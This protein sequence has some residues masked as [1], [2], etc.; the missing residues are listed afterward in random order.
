MRNHFVFVGIAAALFFAQD[1]SAWERTAK[2]ECKQEYQDCKSEADSK[3][4][5]DPNKCKKMKEDCERKYHVCKKNAEKRDEESFQGQLSPSAFSKYQGF[6]NQQK[7][8]AMDHADHNK[9][10]PNDAVEKVAGK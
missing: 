1:L 2:K 5:T 7:I 3:C 8:K 4:A 10:S 6:S 9:M